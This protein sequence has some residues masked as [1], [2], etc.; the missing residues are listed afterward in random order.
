M[1]APKAAATPAAAPADTKS[2]L[3]LK[4]SKD[5]TMSFFQGSSEE[6]LVNKSGPQPYL[7]LRKYGKSNLILLKEML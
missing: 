1:G 2:R 3:S 7:S 4:N 5:I 6:C